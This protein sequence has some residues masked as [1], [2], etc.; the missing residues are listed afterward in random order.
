MFKDMWHARRVWRVGLEADA[1]DIVLIVSCH[2]KIIGAGLVV[3]EHQRRQLQLRHV[4]RLFQSEAMNAVA[5]L[6]QRVEHRGVVAA[7]TCGKAL[8]AHRRC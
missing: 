6:G 1:E 7:R 2:M 3:L 5:G 4:L 8:Q